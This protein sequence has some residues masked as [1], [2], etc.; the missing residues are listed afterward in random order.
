MNIIAWFKSKNLNSH[1]IAAVVFGAAGI[2]AFDPSVQQFVTQLCGA[3]AGLAAEI[4]GAAVIIAKYSHSSSPAG[5]Y[6]TARVLTNAGQTP[7]SAEVDAASQ[8]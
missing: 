1:W 8:K 5:T 7:T 6:A 3:H 4:I 2:V